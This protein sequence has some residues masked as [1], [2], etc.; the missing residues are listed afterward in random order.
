MT[1]PST[2][3]PNRGFS[4]G[5]VS[6]VV[7]FATCASPERSAGGRWRG[8]VDT[9]ASGTIVV[10]NPATGIW[11]SASAWRIDEELRIGSAEGDDA[12]AFNQIA[13]LEVDRVGRIYVVESQTQEIRV[14]DSAGRFLRTIGRKGRGPGEFQ[15]AIGMEWDPAGRLWVVDQGNVRYTLLDSAARVLGTRTRPLSGWFTWRWQG[16]LDSTGLVYE[17][18]RKPDPTGGDV[19]LRYDT[20]FKAADTFPLPAYE[21]E[22]F[23]IEESGRRIWAS[24]PFTPA[25]SWIFD[26]RGYV[27]FGITAPYR[28][29]QRRLEG[30]TVRVIER[31]YEP[32]PVTSEDRDSVIARL[33][34]F[35]KQG[36]KVDASRIPRVKPAFDSFFLDDRGYLWVDPVTP[37]EDE[38]RV[39]DVFDP[40]GRY[41]GRARAN[42]RLAGQPVFRGDYLHATTEDESGIPYV[43]RARI[44]RPSK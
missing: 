23:K 43:I 11:D 15:Q 36:G 6:A 20:A 16:G 39:F 24:V 7:L 9:L 31:A 8:T 22:V 33:D 12:L 28:I 42:V 3:G 32:L 29:Y 26:P 17:W 27:W 5:M 21:G 40:D 44:I 10:H 41:L 19:L 2:V 30:D 38:G 1:A 4:R 35:T 37:K 14:F 13:D 25:L 34:W 18:Y